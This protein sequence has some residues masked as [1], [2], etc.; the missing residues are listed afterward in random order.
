MTRFDEAQAVADAEARRVAS[1]SWDELDAFGVQR[2]TVEGPTGM[3]FRL[4]ISVS[5]DAEPRQ[6]QLSVIVKARPTRGLRLLRAR[7]AV[8]TRMPASRTGGV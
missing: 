5:W 6:S 3:I 4:R 8:R 1:L 7:K 2:A